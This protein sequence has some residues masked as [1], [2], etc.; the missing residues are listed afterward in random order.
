MADRMTGFI[1]VLV[2]DD[3]ALVR[4]GLAI[5]LNAQPDIEVVGQAEDG[6][7]AVKLAAQLEPDVVLMDL[8][9]PV[10]DGVEATKEIRKR[11]PDLPEQPDARTVFL[12]LRELRNS[13]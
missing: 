5:I 7:Q 8:I 12:K 3:Q 4:E 10:M 13:W 6:R 2:V 9:M 1:R 11:F